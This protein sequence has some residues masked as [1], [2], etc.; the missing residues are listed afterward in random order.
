[1]KKRLLI[2]TTLQICL[3]LTPLQLYAYRHGYQR[4]TDEIYATVRHDLA[5][6][7]G[8]DGED[9]NEFVPSFTGIRVIDR[10]GSWRLIEY[11][12]K[13]ET[14]TGWITNDDFYAD[15]LVYDGRDKQIAADGQYSVTWREKLTPEQTAVSVSPAERSSYE[16]NLDLSLTYAGYHTYLISKTGTSR[17]LQADGS[18][19]RWGSRTSAGTFRLVRNKDTY[20]IRDDLTGRCLAPGTGGILSFSDQNETGARLVLKDDRI[21]DEPR[22]RVFAQFDADWGKDYYGK[23][24]ND[25]PEANNFCTSGCGIFST[26]NAIY[27][28]TGHFA[29]PHLLADYAV[30]E[31]FRVEGNG[32]DSGFFEAAS[33]EFGRDYGFSYNGSS[34]SVGTLKKKLKAGNVAV[35]HVPGH[36]AAIVDYNPKTK[37]FLLL[38][39][40]YLPKRRTCPYGD[41]ITR[42]T[43]EESDGLTAQMYYFFKKLPL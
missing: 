4:K 2:L 22:L 38:D 21:L 42:K 41:W 24:K 35:A 17:F 29:D 30:E 7:Y 9:F 20:L 8:Q 3:L 6:Y 15:C 18:R 5:V 33:E 25:D 1:M 13:K 31:E 37:K 39:S 19:K 28:L 23:G 12:K 14:R 16:K 36:Y 40:H 32:T 26:L 34:D 27:T 10:D 43:L 11:T